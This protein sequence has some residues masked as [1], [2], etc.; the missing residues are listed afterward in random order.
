VYRQRQQQLLPQ[1]DK[2]AYVE[3][4]HLRDGNINADSFAHVAGTLKDLTTDHVN[5]NTAAKNN[6]H[7]TINAEIDYS[8]PPRYWIV[9]KKLFIVPFADAPNHDGT[10]TGRARIALRDG[11]APNLLQVTIGGKG[12]LAAYMTLIGQ[13]GVLDSQ[14]ATEGKVSLLLRHPVGTYEVHVK[15]LDKPDSVYTASFLPSK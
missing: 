13:K 7:S 10:R 1:I 8:G 3:G 15:M 4:I 11:F 5:I 2:G 9:P 12:I 14:D 6:A